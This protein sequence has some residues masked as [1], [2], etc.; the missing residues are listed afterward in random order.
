[1]SSAEYH[2]TVGYR[3]GL[4]TAARIARQSARGRGPH[5]V[6]LLVLA[7]RLDT[8]AASPDPKQETPE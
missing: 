7:R 8:I 1:M 6:A 5:G 3:A 2:H 4:E